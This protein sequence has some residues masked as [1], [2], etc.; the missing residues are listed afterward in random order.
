ML[1]KKTLALIIVIALVV[2][3]II[4]FGLVFG[5]RK[6]EENDDVE[7]VNSY[8]NTDELIKKF[9]VE[10]PITVQDGIEKRI[11][12]RLLTGFENWNRGFK[13]WK[14]W[15]DIL[16]T[17]ASIYNTNGVRLT[18][19]E[20]QKAMDVTLKQIPIELG[21]FHIMLICGNY[22]AIYYDSIQTVR[23]VKNKGTVMEFVHFEEYDE[24]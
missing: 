24:G 2:I 8:D 10:Y 16:Y 20:Y 15:G 5:L 13:A 23:G 12:N 9:P 18:L 19:A 14:K 11:Q 21:Q 4:T 22:T 1:S 3:L 17:N 7:I 6:S